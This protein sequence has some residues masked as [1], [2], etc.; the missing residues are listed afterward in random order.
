MLGG[1][2]KTQRREHVTN[3][4]NTGF[5]V[6][7]RRMNGETI[8]IAQNEFTHSMDSETRVAASAPQNPVPYTVLASNSQP[9][10][11]SQLRE[12]LDASEEANATDDDVEQASAHVKAPDVVQTLNQQ[13]QQAAPAPVIAATVA[14]PAVAKTRAAPVK[15]A[16]AEPKTEK[17]DKATKGKKKKNPDAVWSIQVGAFKDKALANDWVKNIHKRFDEALADA[18]SQI[19]KSDE[20]WYR[21]R[22]ASLTKSQA[23]TACKAISAKRL[24]CMVVK[25]DA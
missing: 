13:P 25:P 3:L 9:L 24:D 21:T 7:E 5:S 19:S 11:D 1:S 20:G 17:A 18:T 14:A 22:F 6:I 12:T 16:M 2:N 15:L 23:Q 8:T 4:M 10:S